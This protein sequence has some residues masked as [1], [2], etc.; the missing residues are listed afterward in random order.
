MNKVTYEEIKI[1]QDHHG[2]IRAEKNVPQGARFLLC[3]PTPDPVSEPTPKDTIETAI[4][5][6]E[7]HPV[8]SN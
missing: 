6:T 4:C 5:E 2:S 3:L 1:A 7:S 8:A